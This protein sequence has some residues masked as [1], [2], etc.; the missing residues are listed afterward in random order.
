MSI[1]PHLTR[2]H[3]DPAGTGFL[4][5]IAVPGC[6]RCLWVQDQPSKTPGRRSTCENGDFFSLLLFFFSIF[7]WGSPRRAAGAAIPAPLSRLHPHPGR[8]RGTVPARRG[9]RR[10]PPVPGCLPSQQKSASMDF[11]AGWPPAQPLPSA[12]QRLFLFRAG[13][14]RRAPFTAAFPRHKLAFSERSFP[15]PGPEPS[16]SLPSAAFGMLRLEFCAPASF[17]RL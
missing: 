10:I 14:C 8:E 6:L 17:H 2:G 13:S 15:S 4:S 9:C 16:A 3:R 5:G 11:S 12:L 7:L 1:T